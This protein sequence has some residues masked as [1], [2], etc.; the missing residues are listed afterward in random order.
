MRES[1]TFF[2]TL[3]ALALFAGAGIFCVAGCTLLDK[4]DFGDTPRNGSQRPDSTQAGD[5]GGVIPPK[6]DTIIYAAG[7]RFPIGYDWAIDTLVHD[8]PRE[9]VFFRNGQ[10]VFC[11]PVGPET[12]LSE[13]P[14][15]NR[16]I[17]GHVYSNYS[18]YD[19]TVIS[20]DGKV[21]F[22][23]PV[24][25]RIDGFYVD[26]ADIW[27]LGQRTGKHGGLCLRKNGAAV[28]TDDEG[29]TFDSSTNPT[30]PYGTLWF[31]G[32]RPCFFYYTYED[33]VLSACR[34]CYLVEE[35]ERTPI[36]L[37][38]NMTRVLDVKMIDG[39]IIVAGQFSN[40]TRSVKI[41]KDATLRDYAFAGYDRIK[42]CLLA[43]APDGGFYI[44]GICEASGTGASAGYVCDNLGK[45]R[46]YPAPGRLVGLY[47]TEASTVIVYCSE[48]GGYPTININS[49][50]RS[51]EGNF[52]YLSTRSGFV[53]GD[54]FFM[55]FASM[56]YT[57]R[58]FIYD[59]N[60]R[61]ILDINGFIFE[62][63]VMVIPKS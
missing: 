25:E 16:I 31:R 46:F 45:T 29:W 59:G 11:T 27:T 34:G 37:P 22:S 3:T 36:A 5:S 6:Y 21:L 55:A 51:L 8:V 56:D 42:S 39:S 49:M 62:T 20:R 19:K 18:E 13:S 7:I 23:I 12:S 30:S 15:M 10:E 33:G 35:N 41:Y 47:T 58:P 63:S 50:E 32:G 26:G 44:T 1:K 61:R 4:G 38:Q 48:G 43:P 17:D 54:M 40:N 2:L 24:K 14:D 9:L 57:L 60:S 53:L 52:R 28:F